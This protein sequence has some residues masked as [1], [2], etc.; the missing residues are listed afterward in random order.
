VQNATNLATKLITTPPSS[1]GKDNQS[2]AFAFHM[3]ISGLV[4]LRAVYADHSPY[5]DHY[6]YEEIECKAI[7]AANAIDSVVDIERGAS[8][9]AKMSIDGHFAEGV[10]KVRDSQMSSSLT[11]AA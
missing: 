1:T 2:V 10:E 8:F 9:L 7:K 3:L 4:K 6:G 11:F 5:T